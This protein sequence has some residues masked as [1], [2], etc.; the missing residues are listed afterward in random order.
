M[1]ITKEDGRQHLIA[2][3][4]SIGYGDL[5]SGTAAAAI[6]LPTGAIVMGG[7]VVVDTAFNSGT[8][9]QLVVGDSSDDDRYTSSAI[10][11]QSTGLT[12]LTLTG[13]QHTTETD[14][15][16]VKWTGAGTAPSSGSFRLVV[17][18][19]VAGRTQFTHDG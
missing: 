5:E 3:K 1:G 9:D 4:V 11:L 13:Y 18:Y 7:Y 17:L 19:M 10:D 14:A 8:S 15:I 6:D 12:E 2:A 16:A